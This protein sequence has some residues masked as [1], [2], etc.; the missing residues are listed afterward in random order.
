MEE[1]GGLQ[2]TGRKESDTTE[3]LHFHFYTLGFFQLNFGL[4]YIK[5]AHPLPSPLSVLIC[6]QIQRYQSFLM[7]RLVLEKNVSSRSAC[8]NFR[9]LGFLSRYF[10]FGGKHFQSG[11]LLA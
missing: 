10:V 7:W 5:I 4:L 2:S 1:L 9:P 3:R 11:L 6:E 8:L